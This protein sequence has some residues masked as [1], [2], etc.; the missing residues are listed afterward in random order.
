MDKSLVQKF[1]HFAVIRIWKVAKWMMVSLFPWPKGDYKLRIVQRD[2]KAL[3]RDGPMKLILHYNS[4]NKLKNELWCAAGFSDEKSLH[5]NRIL[6]L[7]YTFFDMDGRD[8]MFGGGERYLLELNK[9][10]TELGYDLE[11]YQAANFTWSS[12]YEGIKVVGI[13]IEGD[14]GFLNWR[15]H[16]FV[17]KGAL[18]IYSPY[19]LG[20]PLHHNHSI[21]I[22]HGIFWDFR[23]YHEDWDRL[24][25]TIT[26][27][28]APLKNI[29]RLVSVDTNTIN[30]TRTVAYNQAE[31]WV[32]IPNFVDTDIFRP[33]SEPEKREEIVILYPR[34]LYEPRGFWLVARIIP[35]AVQEYPLIKFMFVGQAD[36]YEK[37]EIERL[38]QMFPSS[39]E[40]KSVAPEEMPK[41]YSQA[42]ITL[43]PTEYSEGTSLSCLEAMA[44]GNAVIAT[45]VGGLPNLVIDHYNGLLIKPDSEELLAALKELI[46]QPELRRKL[47]KNGRAIAESFS[48]EQWRKRWQTLLSD[49]LPKQTTK[50]PY[51]SRRIF[52]IP[53]T[54]GID[55]EG[56][57]QRPHAIASELAAHGFRTI[58]INSDQVSR[59]YL[60]NLQILG[61]DDSI[62]VTQPVLYIYY[63]YNY[64]MI[65]KYK[66]PFVVYDVLDDISIHDQSDEDNVVP[67]NNNARTNHQRLLERA[68]LVIT[69]SIT[70][71]EQLISIRPDALCILNGVDINLFNPSAVKVNPALR[72]IRRPIIGFHGSIADWIDLPLLFSLAERRSDLSFVLIGPCAYHSTVFS[73]AGIANVHYF[74]P[75]NQQE[76]PSWIAGFDAEF[77]PFKINTIT[78]GVR[79]LK[80]LESL[81]M[82]KP[83]ISTPIAS[84]QDW[85]GVY[86]GDTVESLSQAIDK[87]LTLPRN[88]VQSPLL[89]FV[90]GESWTITTK[91]LINKL[92]SISKGSAG[93]TY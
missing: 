28:I 47:S 15:F 22:S 46:E 58:W 1:F 5:C 87:V 27:A 64:E 84:I 3:W 12:S 70:L 85:P 63:P 34:R 57:R 54:P 33:T 45:N 77:T 13:N 11:I 75:V 91:P 76:I 73:S 29:D 36:T 50:R 49:V 25:R 71:H 39:V 68:D 26:S 8:Y 6:V 72:S 56:V 41:I 80:V 30:W 19:T 55:W 78:H 92:L 43:I 48:L 82:G 24:K 4:P 88:T 90:R 83:V 31:K 7:T 40:W 37:A 69:S 9:I 14:V 17:P 52:Y 81:S 21:G 53:K 60:P 44:S 67:G 86:F 18:T 10:V 35:E 38:E 16:K 93:G 74:P 51:E 62:C 59:T 2:L 20:F 89:D 61:K 66:D 65:S 32:Y 23:T 79:P 42:D